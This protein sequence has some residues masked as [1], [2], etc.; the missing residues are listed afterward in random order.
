VDTDHFAEE[1][2][3]S[4]KSGGHLILSTPNLA[5]WYNRFRLLRGLAPACYPGPSSTIRK[6][7]LIDN[8]H[9]RVNVLSEWTHFLQCHEFQIESIH[10]S[11]H[12]QGIEGGWRIHFIKFIDRLACRRP[13]LS[14]DIILVARKL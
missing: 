14:T 2:H 11:S 7:L 4:L 5:S 3:R 13:P 10:G 8:N 9:I 1:A 12:F 6:D